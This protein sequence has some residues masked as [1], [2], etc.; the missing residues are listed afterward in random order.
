MRRSVTDSEELR[1]R[2]QTALENYRKHSDSVHSHGE[3]IAAIADYLLDGLDRYLDAAAKDRESADRD[4]L[5]AA[6]D[7]KAVREGREADRV[8]AQAALAKE[9]KDRTAMNSF[10]RAIM[11]AAI[12]SAVATGLSATV[13][14]VGIFKTPTPLVIP[15]PVVAPAPAPVVNVPLVPVTLN[16]TICPPRTARSS[17]SK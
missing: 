15:A 4:R 1:N 12:V 3:F 14:I 10:T 16:P 6:E 7:R 2:A 9:E 5:S 11:T 8:V 17:K 13:M